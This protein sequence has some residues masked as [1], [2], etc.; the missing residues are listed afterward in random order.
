MSNL[1]K[2]KK[3]ET[4]ELLERFKGFLSYDPASGNIV[5]TDNRFGATKV[6]QVAGHVDG[7]YVRFYHRGR[8]YFAHRV[9]WALH[10]GK[11]PEHTIDHI[12]RIKTDNRISNLRDV[13]QSVNNTNKGKYNKLDK[14]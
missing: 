4:E 9:A 3:Y 2:T 5:F 6:G 8:Q 13:P 12:N 1:E 11:W 7:G 10:Y 14:A